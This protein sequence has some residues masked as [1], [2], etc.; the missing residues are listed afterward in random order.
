MVGLLWSEIKGYAEN[1]PFRFTGKLSK[2]V[3]DRSQSRKTLARRSQRPGTDTTNGTLSVPVFLRKTVR[4]AL[5][6]GIIR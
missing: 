3:S 2:L 6:P 5:S 4:T 1:M